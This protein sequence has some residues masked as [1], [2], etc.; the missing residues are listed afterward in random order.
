[1]KKLPKLALFPL[2]TAFVVSLSLLLPWC[3]SALQDM[4]IMKGMHR[5]PI[6]SVLELPDYNLTVEERYELL[7]IHNDEMMREAQ[8]NVFVQLVQPREYDDLVDKLFLE[9]NAL[10]DAGVFTEPLPLV[11]TSMDSMRRAQRSFIQDPDTLKTLRIVECNYYCHGAGIEFMTQMDEETGKLLSI[12][13]YSD[14]LSAYLPRS[15][16]A[17]GD[18]Y[19]ERMDAEYLVLGHNARHAD[20]GLNQNKTILRVV[21]DD[22]LDIRVYVPLV[23][24]EQSAREYGI[25][26]S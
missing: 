2:F 11:E 22:V 10:A 6:N 3:F 12:N 15:P 24:Q 9:L 20:F 26:R 4:R 17:I 14:H 8:L 7:S 1:M 25:I 18:A 19:L 5:E 21:S 16:L 23:N 13:V